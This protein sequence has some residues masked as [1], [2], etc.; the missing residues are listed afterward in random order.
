MLPS[1]PEGFMEPFQNP[2]YPQRF[3]EI[4]AVD[5][6][7]IG[8]RTAADLGWIADEEAD[9]FYQPPET[10]PEDLLDEGELLP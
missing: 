9:R 6:L 5:E 8:Y 10:T 3:A 2:L 7:R 1:Y 4:M